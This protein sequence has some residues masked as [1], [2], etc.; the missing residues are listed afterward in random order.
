MFDIKPKT[1]YHWYREHL[2]DYKPDIEHKKWHPKHLEYVDEHTGEITMGKPLYV[3]K[4]ENIGS[5]MS[6]D[7]KGIGHEGF[8]ILSNG[9]TGKIALMIESC[10]SEEVGDAVSLFGKELDKIETISC[11]MS[12]GYLRVCADEL[13]KTKVVIDKFHVMQYVYDAVLAVRLNLKKELTGGLSKEKIKTEQDKEILQK[14]DV[15]KHCRYRLTQSPDKWGEAGKELMHEVFRTHKRLEKV[16]LLSQNFKKWYAR[17]NCAK[18]RCEIENELHGWYKEVKQAD[19]KELNSTVRMIR[20]HENEIINFFRSGQTNA[21][22][23]NLNGKINRFISNNY[24]IKDKDFA[25]Y[26]MANY[27]S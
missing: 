12:A 19:I 22:A 6:I 1:L 9:E 25:L 11:D 4:P 27:F 3:F 10:K 26:R 23:E 24:G 16:Y 2:S 5:K 15:L 7:D 20:K 21:K 13:P 8:T 18:S 14:L 17:E